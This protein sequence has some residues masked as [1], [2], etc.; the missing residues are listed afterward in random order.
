MRGKRFKRLEHLAAFDNSGLDDLGNAFAKGGTRKRVQHSGRAEN[1]GRIG[2]GPGKVFAGAQVDTG[3]AADRGVDHA[4]ERCGDV[5][6][7][8]TAHVNRARKAKNITRD[9]AADAEDGTA[10]L[11]P[12]L[13]ER[14][15]HALDGCQTLTPLAEW[16]RDRRRAAAPRGDALGK[17]ANV[18]ICVVEDS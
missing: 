2:K 18:P 13:R 12:R 3:L 14:F 17:S 6:V 7:A 15:E 16:E 1:R 5:R 9:A 11:G 10:A 8:Y 4:H